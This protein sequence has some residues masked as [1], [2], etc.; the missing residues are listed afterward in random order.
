MNRGLQE[1]NDLKTDISQKQEVFDSKQVRELRREIKKLED[2]H[3]EDTNEKL[4]LKKVVE[5]LQAR[6]KD[7]DSQID[8][9]MS[10]QQNQDG[11]NAVLKDQVRT[12]ELQIEAM[13]SKMDLMKK[14][15]DELNFKYME[16]Q[17]L[18]DQMKS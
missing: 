11:I 10:T 9:V 8:K 13:F 14:N 2:Q 16:A 15:I 17:K 12:K 1:L 3:L 18:L 7:K 4:M 5:G 6:L